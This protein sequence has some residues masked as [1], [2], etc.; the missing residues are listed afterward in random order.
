[1]NTVNLN[2]TLAQIS[3]LAIDAAMTLYAVAF[4][5]L[6][7]NLATT[8]SD[9]KADVTKAKRLERIGVWF[10]V[11]AVVFHGLGVVG[12]GVAA[13][14]V[15][16]ANMYEFSITG[17]FVVVVIFLV[18]QLFRDIRFIAAFV[19]GFV[20]LV[21]GIAETIFYVSV[22][23]LMPALQ[24][25][26]LVI[27]V[28]IAILATAFFNIAA[29]LSI[30][31]LFKTAKWVQEPKGWVAKGNT[32]KIIKAVINKFPGIEKLEQ[33]QSKS[34]DTIDKQRSRITVLE[35]KTND[36]QWSL[37]NGRP[38]IKTGD[39]DRLFCPESVRRA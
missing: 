31:Y 32:V 24:S 34:K 33:Q 15:P 29:A 26:W 12:R 11:A 13:E 27:H 37:D 35:D 5:L 16:W 8:A 30:T 10:M 1:M 6:V 38:T 20:T 3:R 2:E 25:Y 17:T 9:K 4:L 21:L 22:K 36:V 39:G 28:T 7:W 19:A 18:A 23:S 14:R